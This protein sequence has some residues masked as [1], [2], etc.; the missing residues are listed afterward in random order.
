MRHF[1]WHCGQNN[2]RLP[3]RH[4]AIV[5]LSC[6]TSR[7]QRAQRNVGGGLAEKIDV[8]IPFIKVMLNNRPNTNMASAS[9]SSVAIFENNFETRSFI[10]GSPYLSKMPCGEGVS[11]AGFEITFNC[12][13]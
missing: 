4:A 11:A 7:R 5:R 10:L 1:L 13:A 6:D 12:D 8:R 9:L 2:L 3:D